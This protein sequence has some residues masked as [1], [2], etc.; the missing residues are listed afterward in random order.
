MKFKQLLT[1]SLLAAVCLL[2]GQSV[3]GAVEITETYDFG[4]FVAGGAPALTTSGDAIA[5]SGTSAKV[6]SVYLI[7]NPTS[8]ESSVTLDLKGR[9]AVDYNSSAGS[10]IRF[11]WRSSTNAYQNGLAGNW[12]SKGTAD[13]QGA[14]RFSVLNLKK[15]DKIT[16]TYA[17]QSGKAADPYTCSASQLTDVGA[18]VALASGTQ[19]TVAADGNV[20]LYF[21]NN[22]FA[23]SKIVIVTYGTETVSAP[24][25]SIT[26]ADAKARKVTITAGTSDAGN[27]VTTY[28][29][30]DGSTPTTSSASFTTAS[31]EITVGAG[32]ESES[33]VTVKAF[34]VSSASA[35]SSVTSQNVTVGT[36][37][38]LAAPTISMSSFASAGLVY[39]P[40]YS[41]T[42]DQSGVIGTP[43][44]TYSYSFAGGA[45]T[46]G[47]SYTA[48]SSGNITVTVSANGYES[49][50]TVLSIVGG[51]YAKTYS[52]DAINDVTVDTSTGTWENSTGVGGAQW[53]FTSLNNCT[54]SLRADIALTGFMYAR[55][56]TAQTKQGFYARLGS[57]SV[58]FSL[59]DGEYVVFGMR[60]ETNSIANSGATSKSFGQYSNI[61][62]IEIFTPATDVDI[63]ILDCKQHET[64]A[65]FAK[66]VDAETFATADEVYAFHTAWQIENAVS[67]DI[68]KVIF[69]APVSDF[70]R[71]NKARS[72]SGE[73]YTNAPDNKYFDA[74]DSQV[75]DAKQKIYG[76]PAGN[77]SLKVATRASEDLSDKSKYN[78]WV[79]GGSANVSTLGN[80]DGNTGGELGN[81]W[82]WTIIPFT[83]D[84]KADVEI[85]FYSLPGEGS[86]LWAGADDWHLYKLP[87][88]V[89][90]TISTAG[91]STYCS[92]YILD[93]SNSIENLEAAYIVTGGENG[94][95]KTTPVA[96]PVPANTGLL[97]KGTASASVNIPVAATTA[98]VD[99]AGNK[100]KGV[101]ASGQ[102][103][104]A[105]AGYV[106]M[107][108][109]ANAAFYKN[110]NTF[111]LSANSAYLPVN[112]DG[113]GEAEA[114]ASFLLFSDDVTGISQV[115]GSEVKTS[116]AV[117]NLNGQRVSQPVK[118]LYIIDGKK[119]VIK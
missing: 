36:L 39:N 18:D 34:S 38:Q 76:L 98:T 29:T 71:W 28:Y 106:L 85:G 48:S 101:T 108:S 21:T 58:G 111:T 104:D 87:E 41:F 116:G 105:E 73:Q 14:A 13:P 6:G 95:L 17:K 37:V 75:S 79:S 16:L 22:N 25:M 10:Q 42:S 78:V 40:V 31:Q 94:V 45:S 66:V 47:T 62:S 82:S 51:N 102:T 20:D 2:A 117:Y 24:T 81:G 115:A 84:A 46:A 33:T 49:N 69:D 70:S 12:N 103:I 1:K 99:V 77:Y 90:K 67:D 113:N 54:Y 53:T 92:P 118:G 27:D 32:A 88:N 100:L 68:T 114:R 26:G 93:F 72:N 30:T 97:L 44:V 19:Y 50:S 8:T 4:T 57:G 86:K 119:V 23:I 64:S 110:K 35:E 109:G 11:M 83:L 52:F 15:D 89:T 9:F 56:T 43:S 107:A 55:A 96:G 63:A 65:A 59:T 80:H 5:Q 3:W 112:F 60:G 7:N 91:W 61:R 74:W